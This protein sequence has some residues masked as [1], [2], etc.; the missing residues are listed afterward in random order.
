MSAA[1]AASQSRRKR[2]LTPQLL[3]PLPAVRPRVL[4]AGAERRRCTQDWVMHDLL[5]KTLDGMAVAL[6]HFPWPLPC[7]F[8]TKKTAPF[9]V[10][11][12]NCSKL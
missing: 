10:S 12:V 5:A 8:S 4:L 1:A 7:Q 11:L 2:L 3:R 9:S 6:G